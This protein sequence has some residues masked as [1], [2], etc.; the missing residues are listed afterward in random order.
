MKK[1][2]FFQSALPVFMAIAYFFIPLITS[3][4]EFV[5]V[6]TFV[7]FAIFA[8]FAMFAANTVLG[9]S[10]ILAVSA[11][12]AALAAFIVP[13][14]YVVFA[15]FAALAASVAEE[16]LKPKSGFWLLFFHNLLW[17]GAIGFA[18]YNGFSLY[19]GLALFVAGILPLFLFAC[20]GNQ[21]SPTL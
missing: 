3:Y 4:S 9:V 6:A 21:E 7:A 10:A 14:L 19:G 8:I 20:K 12:F 5:R 17:S 16:N 15:V 1:V 2:L 18:I 11:T 13:A